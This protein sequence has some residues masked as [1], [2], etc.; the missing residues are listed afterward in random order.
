MT[1]SRRRLAPTAGGSG[2]MDDLVEVLVG[3]DS[4]VVEDL[5]DAASDFLG[6]LPVGRGDVFLELTLVA[7]AD[8][9]ATDAGMVKD[10]GDAELSA[11]LAVAVGEFG[12]AVGDL[13]LLLEALT[14][15]Q[16]EG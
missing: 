1:K 8:Q 6:Q 14:F 7:H 10:P 3:R 2:D 13:D 16:G 5:I 9:R 4:Y 11:G 12:Q 15:E